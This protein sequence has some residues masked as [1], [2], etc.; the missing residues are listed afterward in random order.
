MMQ[1][2]MK[3]SECDYMAGLFLFI[4]SYLFCKKINKSNIELNIFF[5]TP[6]QFPRHSQQNK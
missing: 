1:K 6:F 5:P 3:N 2:K 4:F